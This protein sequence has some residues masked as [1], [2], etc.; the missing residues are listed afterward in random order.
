MDKTKPFCISK[1]AV[2]RAWLKIKENAGAAGVDEQ[3]LAQFEQDLKG[4]LYKLWNRLSSG[5]YFPPPVRLVEIPK[6]DGGV[7]PLGVPTVADRIAQT[8]V[9]AELEKLVEPVFDDDS[10]GYRPGRSAHDALETCRRRCWRYGWVVDLD[11]KDF[12]GSVDHE[13]MLKAVAHHTDQRWI[14]LYVQRWLKA[15]T[16]QPDG[17]LVERDRGTPQ[18]SAISP[19]LANLYLHY[20]FDLWMRRT[21]PSVPFERYADD[22]IAHC[23]TEAQAEGVREAIGRRL[24]E[25][26]LTLHPDK[27]RVVY[28]KQEGRPGSYEH[29]SFDFLG[30][31]FRPRKAKNKTGQFFVSFSPAISRTAAKRIRGEIRSWRLHHR[32]D[33]SLGELAAFINP[34]VRGWINYYGRFYRSELTSSVLSQINMYLIRW[35]MWKYKRM[36]YSPHRAARFL[37]GIIRSNPTMFTHWQLVSI[38]AG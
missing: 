7:R 11:V 36:R 23:A 34:I 27:T 19:V 3:S 21:F 31:T 4:N 16:Q 2:W 28:C 1:H 37:G 26:G 10:Y 38:K 9:A 12:F 33:Q 29:V 20:A 30:Y 15:P 22:A 35:A 25:C 18:G 8:V 32:T 24:A 14:L 5:S 6:R 17:T 13:L